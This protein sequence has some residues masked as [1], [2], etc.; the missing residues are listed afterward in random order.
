MSGVNEMAASIEQVS[1][2][3]VS[4]A[5]SIARERSRR[6][7]NRPPRSSRWPTPPSAWPPGAD[8]SRESIDGDG[9]IGPHGR[10]ATS[11]S[12]RVVGRG[13]RRRSLI[14][15]AR[16]G[17]RRVRQRRRP[18]RRRGRDRVV[19]QRDGGVD[20]RSRRDDGEPGRDRRAELD[21]HRAGRAVGAERRA[22]RPADYRRRDGR[23]D[24]RDADGAVDRV[25]GVD[26]PPRRRGRHGACRRKRRKAA[27]RS[28]DRS[29]ASA[30]CARR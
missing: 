28:S 21:G 3:T 8:R 18:R 24:Q 22:E 9:S 2:N 29:R 15:M 25:G 1:A 16:I 20:R 26:G 17:A 23:R 19:D 4:L 14:E 10:H 13:D 7:G 5:S 27:P 30:G 11:K 6:R 12:L